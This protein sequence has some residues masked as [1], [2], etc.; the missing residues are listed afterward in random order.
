MI[1]ALLMALIRGRNALCM[2]SIIHI[3]EPTNGTHTVLLRDYRPSLG[4]DL[5]I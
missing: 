5:Y 2:A 3:I 4:R 1:I